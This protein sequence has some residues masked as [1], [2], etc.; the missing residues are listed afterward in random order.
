MRICS[1]PECGKKHH[2]KGYCQ[3]HYD[4]IVKKRNKHQH[5]L[6]DNDKKGIKVIHA[7]SWV[8]DSV[9]RRYRLMP[10]GSIGELI[11]EMD[12]FPK[13]EDIDNSWKGNSRIRISG[14]KKTSKKSKKLDDILDIEYD[15]VI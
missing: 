7:D 5:E 1:V 14:G 2:A 11:G 6:D 15:D 12:A 4:V 8:V 10:D 3:H 13:K 9:V